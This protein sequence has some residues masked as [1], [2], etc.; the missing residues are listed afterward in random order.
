MFACVSPKNDGNAGSTLQLHRANGDLVSA[1]IGT[2]EACIY[3]TYAGTATFGV[4]PGELASMDA[5]PMV[6][7]GS[8]R[9]NVSM[10][11]LD[12]FL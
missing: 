6:R 3:S 2:R 12:R 4:R 7:H 5:S 11:S 10:W 1:R 8:T 9:Y